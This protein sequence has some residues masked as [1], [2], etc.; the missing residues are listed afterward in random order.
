[1]KIETKLGI[2]VFCAIIIFSVGIIW[3]S[4]LVLRA[5]GYVI[6]GS[7]NAVNG[8]LSGAEVRYRGYLIGTVSS[9]V[10]DPHDIKVK[11]YI[12]RGINITEGSTLRVDFDGLIGEKYINIV[13]NETSTT[14]VRSGATLKGFTAAGLVDFVNTGTQNLDET[15]QI[16]EV[17]RKII[18]SK[19]S[20]E[21]LQHFIINMDSVTKKLDSVLG[22]IDEFFNKTSMNDWTLRINNIII[23]LDELLKSLNAI[24]GTIEDSEDTG[25]I[26]SMIEN[27]ESFTKTLEQETAGIMKDAKSVSSRVKNNTNFLENTSLKMSASLINDNEYDLG[28]YFSV[29]KNIFGLVVGNKGVGNSAKITQMTYGRKLTEGLQ[30][31][32]GLVENA[33]GV[34]IEHDLTKTITLEHSLYNAT[35]WMYRLKTNLFFTP[36]VK[37]IAGYDYRSDANQKLFLGVGVSSF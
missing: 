32:V 22:N 31:N 19:K 34:K 2:F 8:L 9:M 18:T 20:E 37:A 4:S 35:N 1:M 25:S 29:S 36:N 10:P 12:K 14:F 23:G 15:K 24:V 17:F 21:S 27:L 33:P 16:L 26:Y 7:F 13:P 6:Y 5:Q 3:K 30:A 28:S 11:L